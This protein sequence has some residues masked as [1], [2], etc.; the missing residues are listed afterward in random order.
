MAPLSNGISGASVRMELYTPS[1][2]DDIVVENR[3]GMS[4]AG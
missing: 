1:F 3:E 2:K 4:V